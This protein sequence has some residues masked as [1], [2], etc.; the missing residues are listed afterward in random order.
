MSRFVTEVKNPGENSF[1]AAGK[2]FEY[3][4]LSPD[5]EAAVIAEAEGW[6]AVN[7][8]EEEI[9]NDDYGTSTFRTHEYTKKVTEMQSLSEEMASY[10]FPAGDILVE[11]GKFVGVILYC[12]ENTNRYGPQTITPLTADPYYG[13][14]PK[15]IRPD[16]GEVRH[17]FGIFYTDG[18][19][20]GVCRGGFVS[21]CSGGNE[22]EEYVYC[23]RKKN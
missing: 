22:Y 20:E 5:V 11:D 1:V 6:E 21:W 7:L 16:E 17:G 14:P 23:L 10:S 18:R 3:V 2:Y 9:E 12:G 15:Y 8:F 13:I 19:I 4:T